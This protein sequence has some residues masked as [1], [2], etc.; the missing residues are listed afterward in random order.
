[1]RVFLDM[2][3]LH[4]PYVASN[5]AT[6]INDLSGETLFSKPFSPSAVKRLAKLFDFFGYDFALVTSD[7][8]Y[9]TPG[10]LR[11]NLLDSYDELIASQG[12]KLSVRKTLG[13]GLSGFEGEDV[14][15]A[16]CLPK[17][18]MMSDRLECL[19][20]DD[21]EVLCAVSGS[22]LFDISPAGTDK[23]DALKVVADYYCIPMENVCA[24]GDYDNDISMFE[25]VGFGVAMGNSIES[26]LDVAHYQTDTNDNEGIA[27]AIE[28]LSPWLGR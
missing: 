26:L 24:M 1:M 12:G 7:V 22:G 25:S 5:G 17:N 10:Y 27:K 21:A 13:F 3:E 14:I 2:L 23:S 9:H 16:L 28:Y 8:F 15:K 19:L 6:V 18:T 11:L 4:G 20:H